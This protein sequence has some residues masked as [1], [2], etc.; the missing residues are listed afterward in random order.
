MK[1]FMMMFHG[2]SPKEEEFESHMQEWVEWVKSIGESYHFGH[3]FDDGGTTIKG[4]D[5]SESECTIERP[6]GYLVM[7]AQSLEEV[8]EKAK[9]APHQKLGG[10]TH[11]IPLAPMEMEK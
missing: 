6:G 11:V 2:G 4:P 10:H 9:S 7:S 3:P 8:V 5:N 1:K